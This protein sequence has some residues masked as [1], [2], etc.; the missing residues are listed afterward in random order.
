[1]KK[2]ISLSIALII[3]FSSFTYASGDSSYEDGFDA[4]YNE[5]YIICI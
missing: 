5:G 4:G 3:A 2:I 1:M